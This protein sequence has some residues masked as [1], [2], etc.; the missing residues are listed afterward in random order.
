MSELTNCV[1]Q[2]GALESC[3]T[4]FTTADGK[5]KCMSDM[6]T[7][8]MEHANKARKQETLGDWSANWAQ[9]RANWNNCFDVKALNKF[10]CKSFFSKC[11][12][13]SFYK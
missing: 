13:N 10:N 5:E 12:D 4:F 11:Y 2:Q 3:L 6:R 8:M 9:N 7:K 1:R